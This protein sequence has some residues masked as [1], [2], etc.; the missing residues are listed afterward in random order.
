M[1]LVIPTSTILACMNSTEKGK[2]EKTSWSKEDRH[3]EKE[4][5]CTNDDKAE[6]GCSGTCDNSSCHCPN[7]INIPIYIA[8]SQLS[9]T[10]NF[11]PWQIDWT[12]VQH[13][14]K[15][16]YLSIWQLPKIS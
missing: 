11:T 7:P 8:E 6:D 5:C 10:D 12:F 2:T 3:S 16:V 1:L 14:P 15:A 13:F 4:L 9:S